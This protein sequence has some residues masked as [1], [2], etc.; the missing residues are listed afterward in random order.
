MRE[1][2]REAGVDVALINRYFDSK[3][4]LFKATL[5]TLD[6]VDP[7]DFSSPEDFIEAIHPAT[8]KDLEGIG[9]K[10]PVEGIGM[11]EWRVRDVFGRILIIQTRAYFVP[12]ASIRLFSPQTY[13]QEHRGGSALFEWDKVTLTVPDG[14]IGEFPYNSHSNL[15]LMLQDWVPEAGLCSHTMCNLSKGDFIEQTSRLLEQNNLNLDGN[16]KELSL[17]H[18]RLCHIGF[19]RI[20]ELM[21]PSKKDHIDSPFPPPIPSKLQR[22]RTVQPPLCPACQLSKQTR[23]TTEAYTRRGR[24]P[25]RIRKELNPGDMISLD[26]YDSPVLGRLGHTRGKEADCDKVKCGS[27]FVDHC[28]GFMFTHHQSSLRTEDALHG[29]HLFE[30]F[31]KGFGVTIKTYHADNHPFGSAAFREDIA[32][33]GQQLTFSGVGAHHQNGVAE[34]AQQTV[35]RMARAMMLHLL[36]HWPENFE[37]N[38]WPFALDQAVHIWNHTPR[39]RDGLAPIELF[40]GVKL[41]NHDVLQHA[42]VFGCPTYVLDPKLQDGKKLPKWRRKSR[43]GVYLGASTEHSPTVARVLN[44]VSGYISPQYHVVFDEYFSTVTSVLT[45]DSFDPAMWE[46]LLVREGLER[47]LDQCEGPIPQELFQEFVDSDPDSS[48]PEGDDGV[49]LSDSDSTTS[50][51]SEGSDQ[52]ELEQEPVRTRS[53]RVI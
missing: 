41:P 20:Q 44:P 15:P 29:K 14:A 13:F 35:F 4:G 3:L 11:I 6:P 1:I 47:N 10:V 32:A 17:W 5:E 52:V 26:N 37:P 9:N 34:R 39:D 42:R 49:E 2:A 38:L 25:K 8:V 40:T 12:K 51:E 22:T 53:G 46:T 45:D 21:Y 31:A 50:E 7:K 28:T 27:M 23:R 16:G 19:G 48:V 33:Q 30:Q 24:H 43:L 36:I 18:Y